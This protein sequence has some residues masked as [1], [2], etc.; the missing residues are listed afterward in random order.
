M[1]V[2][3]RATNRK[4]LPKESYVVSLRFGCLFSTG[5]RLC[6]AELLCQAFL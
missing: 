5:V 2:E 6:H 3:S 1:G 4:G